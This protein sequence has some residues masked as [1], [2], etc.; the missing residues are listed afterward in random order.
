MNSSHNAVIY[1]GNSFMY[2]ENNMVPKPEP[3]G[4]PNVIVD[5]E[6]LRVPT[7]IQSCL[8]VRSNLKSSIPQSGIL[9]RAS[10]LRSR[11][12]SKTP[13]FFFNQ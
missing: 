10:F 4:I 2:R 12:G 13:K 6:D 1:N 3:R 8:L 9:Q 7:L 11:L 5:K